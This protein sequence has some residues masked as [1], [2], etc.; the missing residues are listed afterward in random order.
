V[1]GHP[2]KGVYLWLPREDEH[3]LAASLGMCEQDRAVLRALIDGA[4]EQTARDHPGV[5]VRVCRWHVWRVVRAMHRAG[6][7]NTAEG[8][9]TAY[10]VLATQG[11]DDNE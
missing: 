8:R 5:P 4:C 3:D 7:L 6:V 10:M 9:S 11:R 2:C 1:S